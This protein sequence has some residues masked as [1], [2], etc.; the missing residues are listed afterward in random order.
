MNRKGITL[1]ELLVALGVSGILLAG[2]YRT[3]LS[4]QHTFTVQDQVVDMQQNARL[5]INRMTRE[6][7]MAG[8]GGGGVDN[9][10]IFLSHGGMTVGGD[11]FNNVV[12]PGADGKSITVLEAYQAV[13][14]LQANTV[15]GSKTIQ[16]NDASSFINGSYISING[17]D[18]Y[19]IKSKLDATNVELEQIKD[20]DNKDVA[21]PSD[22]HFAGEIVYLV[23]AITYSVGMFEGKSCLLRDDRLGLGAQPVA[24][25]VESIQ[26]RNP[27]GSIPLNPNST[28]MQV[29]ITVTTDKTDPDYKVDGGYRKRGLTSHIQLRNLLF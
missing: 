24:E 10:S 19:Q 1:I 22:G 26:F 5:A 27:D 28:C 16:V 9:W 12:N 14:T 6:L 20:I 15:A 25:N 13:T 8:F 18:V 2:V 23:T 21:T 29:A 3:F 4:Q 17:V 11:T 7:R